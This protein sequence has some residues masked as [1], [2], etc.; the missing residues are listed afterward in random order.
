MT[1]IHSSATIANATDSSSHRRRDEDEAEDR[2]TNTR[3]AAPHLFGTDTAGGSN[4]TTLIGSSLELDDLSHDG[5][6]RRRPRRQQQHHPPQSRRA[7]TRPDGHDTDDAMKFS[8][9]IQFNA[10][11]DWSTHYIAY[12]NLKK[13]YVAIG[14]KG[15]TKEMN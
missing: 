5:R 12:S 9:S 4:T 7:A 13:L 15:K 10:V 6:S 2:K 8:H 1:L 3:T 14:R 11:P